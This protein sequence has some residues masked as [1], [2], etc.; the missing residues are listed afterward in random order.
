MN[1]I[2]DELMSDAEKSSA[3]RSILGAPHLFYRKFE[4]PKRRGGM[5]SISSPY[6][7]LA[8]FQSLIKSTFLSSL[9]LPACVYAYA[10][11]RGS[12]S[13]A[14]LHVGAKEL[15][16]MDIKDF[17]PS[18]SRQM[19]YEAFQILGCDAQECWVFSKICTLENGLPQGACTSPDISNLVFI[20]MDLRLQGLARLWGLTYSRYADDMV[21]SGNS[22]PRNLPE[23]VGRIIGEKG[24]SLNSDKTQLKVGRGKRVVTGVSIASGVPKAPKSFKRELRVQIFELER[25][26]GR[27]SSLRSFDPLVYER[28]LGKINYLLQIEPDNKYAL[29]KKKSL[30]EAHQEFL[31]GAKRYSN[32]FEIGSHGG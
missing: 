21:F 13:N 19:V 17:F 16:K 20:R 14:R 4:I 24:F 18:I 15:L 9:K 31:S 8:Y 12:I 11:G 2:I 7:E 1:S 22:I 5:R 29:E 23:I 30:S 6:P 26:K 3:L 28:V 27:L 25:S 32:F 10:P